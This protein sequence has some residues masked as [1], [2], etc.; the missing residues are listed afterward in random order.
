MALELPPSL[1]KN[2][3][4]LEEEVAEA[5]RL[6]PEERL[7]VVAAVCRDALVLLNMNPHRDRV[8]DTRDPVPPSTEAALRR[9]RG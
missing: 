8:L 5:R 3:H 9:L 2:L 7:R 6:T 4:P 1:R